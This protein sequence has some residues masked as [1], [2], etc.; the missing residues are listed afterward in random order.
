MTPVHTVRACWD[1][2]LDRLHAFNNLW[3]LLL[4]KLTVHIVVLIW[5]PILGHN[6]IIHK[7]AGGVDR[8]ASPIGHT[9]SLRHL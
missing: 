3:T 8:E 5:N 2:M 7:F 6:I 4:E 9:K 1:A